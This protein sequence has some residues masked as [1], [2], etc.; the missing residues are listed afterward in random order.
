MVFKIAIALAVMAGTASAAVQS[1]TPTWEDYDCT[2]VHVGSD[3]RILINRPQTE[4]C[5]PAK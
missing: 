1:R 5:D 3:P 4:M 2:G